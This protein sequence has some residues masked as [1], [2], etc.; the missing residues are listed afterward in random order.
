VNGWDLRDVQ[1]I[2]VIGTPRRVETD[3]KKCMHHL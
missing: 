3:K 2:F 1:H